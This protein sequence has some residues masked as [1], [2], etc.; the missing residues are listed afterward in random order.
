MAKS[1]TK[2]QR[3]EVWGMYIGALKAEGPC[4]VCERT[5]HITEIE[6][7]HN[8][9]KSKGGTD[10]FANFRPICRMCNQSMGTMSIEVYKRK[11]TGPE[12]NK[13]PHKRVGG[14]GLDEDQVGTDSNELF[15][16]SCIVDGPLEDLHGFVV[17]LQKF[18]GV[19]QAKS[20]STTHLGGEYRTRV[21]IISYRDDLE[22]DVYQLGLRRGVV[23][24]F[25]HP[26]V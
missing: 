6:V 11:R 8:I 4:F 1:L 23:V 14:Y 15:R 5:I 18:T 19:Y 9:A 25:D 22:S 24:T 13:A 2:G 3:A 16:F 20:H 12:V 26:P 17:D 21:R 10:N 7:G